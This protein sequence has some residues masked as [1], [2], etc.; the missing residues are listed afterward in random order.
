MI[1]VGGLESIGFDEASDMLLLISSTGAGVF[2]CR[3]GDRVARE[4]ASNVDVINL[5]AE[6][7]GPLT[8]KRI[9]ISGLYGGG[10]PS[11]TAD[12]WGLERYRASWP[13]EELILSQPGET[14]IWTTAGQRPSLTKLGGFA[15]EVRAFGFSP[16]GRSLIVATGA[17]LAIY[18]RD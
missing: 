15:S 17:D 5:T 13:D 8:G 4:D 14:I 3:S 1:A 7:I 11:S 6:G 16:T 18:G 9:R 12:G 2:D 10:L